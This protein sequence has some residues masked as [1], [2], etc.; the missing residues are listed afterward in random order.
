MPAAS[1]STAAAADKT[2]ARL[3]G[4][5]TRARVAPKHAWGTSLRQRIR[6]SPLYIALLAADRA[7]TRAPREY[8]VGVLATGNL[9]GHSRA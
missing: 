5:T 3:D 2:A 8:T 6:L 4:A 7:A 1:V 9:S